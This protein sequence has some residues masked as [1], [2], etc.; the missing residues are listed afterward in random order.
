M[1][2][3]D[4]SVVAGLSVVVPSSDTDPY[5]LVPAVRAAARGLSRALGN[6]RQPT[7]A[8]SAS[9]VLLSRAAALRT[10]ATATAPTAPTAAK[11]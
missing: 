8:V 4:S 2:G 6:H 10:K 11:A 7:S 1:R 3:A 5:T 9:S